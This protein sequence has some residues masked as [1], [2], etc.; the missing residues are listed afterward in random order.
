MGVPTHVTELNTKLAEVAASSARAH[1]TE[2]RK[3]AA[4]KA[5]VAEARESLEAV[6]VAMGAGV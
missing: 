6:A 3:A 4:D 5:A 2:G 1:D